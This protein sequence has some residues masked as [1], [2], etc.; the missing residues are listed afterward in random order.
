MMN[1][2]SIIV[3]GAL[4][5]DI[6]AVGVDRFPEPG[7]AVFSG[8]LRIGPGG[9]SSNIAQ[10]AAS[11]INKPG[12]VAMIGRTSQDKY[13]LWRLPLDALEEAGVNVGHVKIIPNEETGK[14]P[15]VA[16]NAVDRL[17]NNQS[18]VLRGVSADFTKEDVD[19]AQVVFENAGRN[20]GI[21]ALSLECPLETAAHAMQKA[22]DMGL[23]VI[24]DP[25]GIEPGSNINALLNSNVY[26]LKPN[27]YEAR[28][29]TGLK[30]TGF[31]TA[32]EAAKKIMSL[33]IPNVLITDGP[34]G[35]Y[36]FSD[37]FQKHIKIPVVGQD[38]DKDATGCGDQVMGAI[39]AYLQEGKTVEEA[40]ELAIAA[41]TLQF[42]KIGIQPVSTTEIQSLH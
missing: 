1:E 4:N 9:K 16:L 31:E 37:A 30:V 25:G 42:Y 29:I 19:D 21:F 3:I 40:A 15:A 28:I 24:L 6:V 13:N 2:I 32:Q 38:G 33:G 7:E 8:E 41:G 20:N 27:V 35:A 18:F 34:N 5:T 14:F 39:C 36:L 26:L 10:M 12:A 11:L 23:K 22:S 17:G